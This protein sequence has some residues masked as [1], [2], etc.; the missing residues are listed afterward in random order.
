[1]EFHKTWLIGVAAC[2]AFQAFAQESAPVQPAKPAAP[3]AATPAPPP[4]TSAQPVVSDSAAPASDAKPNTSASSPLEGEL[5]AE[6]IMAAQRAGYQIKNEN[7]QTLLCRRDLQ[8]GS[9]VRYK[10]SCLTAREWSQLEEDNKL[11]LKTMQRQPIKVE[12]R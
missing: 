3:V 6:K 9:R 8:T 7:G 2:V 10:T 12:G 4:A 5:D 11:Q 1:M